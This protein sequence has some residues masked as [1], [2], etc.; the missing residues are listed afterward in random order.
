MNLQRQCYS[1]ITTLA[2]QDRFGRVDSNDNLNVFFQ[3]SHTDDKVN[4]LWAIQLCSDDISL[5]VNGINLGVI[6]K[7]IEIP[8]N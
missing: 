8:M 2:L 6:T 7:T 5:I 1:F 4:S 3:S